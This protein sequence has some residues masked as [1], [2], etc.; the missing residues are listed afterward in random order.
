[1]IDLVSC[2]PINYIL[3]AAGTDSENNSSARSM[4]T[5][6][7]IRL[8]KLLRVARISRLLARC[9]RPARE[10]LFALGCV[11]IPTGWWCRAEDTSLNDMLVA[12]KT[13]SMASV[14]LWLTHLLSCAWYWIGSQDQA[15]EGNVPAMPGWVA[16]G[17]GGI[18]SSNST[19]YTYYLL[20]FHSVNPKL[21]NVG[22]GVQ[23][24]QTNMELLFSIIAE[25]VAMIVF[26]SATRHFPTRLDLCRLP[27]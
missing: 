12:F 11:L 2:I 10:R 7:I 16:G 14:M 22:D 27:V 8:T 18:W 1:M 6:R 19:L 5:L 17:G 4:K 9:A 20:A 25:L 13:I 24:A 26:V 23:T 15:A 3:L 21:A